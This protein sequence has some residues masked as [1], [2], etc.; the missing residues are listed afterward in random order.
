[1]GLTLLRALQVR[2]TSWPSSF[3]EVQFD[4][5]VSCPSANGNGFAILNNTVGNLRGRAALIKSSNGVV[6]GNTFFN[7]MNWA[8][9]MAPEYRFSEADFVHGIL[10]ADN[11]INSNG[12]GIWLG[13]DP[14]KCVLTIHPSG[15]CLCLGLLRVG[16]LQALFQR[17]LGIGSWEG[18]PVMLNLSI[19]P[20]LFP[21]CE[22]CLLVWQLA[23]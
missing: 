5:V 20:C 8:V 10:F 7:L 19:W 17:R 12:S 14:W 22:C 1:M 3:D 6:A 21:A 13:I 11:V 2:F 18:V 16:G 9:E 4:D 23:F 15:T